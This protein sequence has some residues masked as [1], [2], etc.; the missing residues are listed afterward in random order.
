MAEQNNC[1]QR[2]CR[3][4]RNVLRKCGTG[5]YPVI[6]LGRRL[7]LDAPACRSCSP[8]GAPLLGEQCSSIHCTDP[9]PS[10]PQGISIKAEMVPI[11]FYTDAGLQ[12]SHSQINFCACLMPTLPGPLTVKSYLST[13]H[14]SH[15][16]AG[17]GD[18]FTPGSFPRLQYVVLRGIKQPQDNPLAPECQAAQDPWATSAAKA[19]L[20]AA[21]CMIVWIHEGGRVHTHSSNRLRL[22]PP[23]DVSVDS[24]SNL[25]LVMVHLKTAPFK[26]GVDIFLGCTD[27][28]L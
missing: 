27:T 5:G 13:I 14:H 10:Y 28:K 20:R 1:A 18:P 9:S 26:Q 19:M 22:S 25:S 17:H 7:N 2:N 4:Q 24:H 3:V 12:P 15:I 21:C 16:I 8:I 6:R 23:L 11:H